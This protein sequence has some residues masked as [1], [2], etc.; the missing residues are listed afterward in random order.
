MARVVHLHLDAGPMSPALVRISMHGRA[1]AAVLSAAAAELHHRFTVPELQR[2]DH[3]LLQDLELHREDQA[4]WQH[5]DALTP[6]E[7]A[8]IVWPHY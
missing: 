4:G 1:F 7:R 2:L 3:R 8:R 5:L 6:Q